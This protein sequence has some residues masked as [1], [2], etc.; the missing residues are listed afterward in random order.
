[1]LSVSLWVRV[2]SVG[3]YLVSPTS[4]FNW[5]GSFSVSYA[6]FHTR[7]CFPGYDNTKLPCSVFIAQADEA[8]SNFRGLQQEMQT[9][10]QQRQTFVA[11]VNENGMVKA[12]LDFL[13]DD[14]TVYKLVGPILVSTPLEEAKSNV[15]KRLEFINN[16]LEKVQNIYNEKDKLAGEARQAL[17]EIQNGMRA[18]AA[19][20]ARQAAADAQSEE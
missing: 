9:L 5:G 12:E 1:M 20:A 6:K 3:L 17:F 4:R 19:E 16:E 10:A 15:E 18:D 2:R 11:Q 8:M 14:A 13:E 7:V